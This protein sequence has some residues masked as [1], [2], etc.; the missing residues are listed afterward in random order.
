MNI[1]LICSVYLYVVRCFVEVQS[2]AGPNVARAILINC[3]VDL[4]AKAI[5]TNMKQWNGKYGCVYCEEEGT[6]GD[7]HLPRTHVS[8]LKNA[9]D[10][11]SKAITVSIGY[12]TE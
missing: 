4:P 2:P 3:S 9:E 5:L 11:A 8:L 1:V 7:D 10:A 6:I 12:V